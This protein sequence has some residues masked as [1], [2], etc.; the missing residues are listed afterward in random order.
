MVPSR[1]GVVL[2][3]AEPGLGYCQVDVMKDNAAKR[4]RILTGDL[5]LNLNVCPPSLGKNYGHILIGAD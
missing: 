5:V 3:M 2:K 4:C 1:P